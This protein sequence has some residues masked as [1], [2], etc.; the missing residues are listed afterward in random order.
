MV[1]GIIKTTVF[2]YQTVHYPCANH[3]VILTINSRRC[4]SLQY[5]VFRL[6]LEEQ[7]PVMTFTEPVMLA[8]RAIK[9]RW[10][11]EGQFWVAVFIHQSVELPML[12]KS[13]PHFCKLP[14]DLGS[15]RHHQEKINKNILL[16]YSLKELRITWWLN[17]KLLEMWLPLL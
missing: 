9:A 8:L 17:S 15:Q 4:I 11:L 13:S 5:P 6:P 10:H 2:Q 1:K 12:R 7:S 16:E 3:N 14:N